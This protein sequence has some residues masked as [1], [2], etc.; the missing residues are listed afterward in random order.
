M[1]PKTNS[2]KVL[3][4]G[5]AI[6]MA[7]LIVFSAQAQASAIQLNEWKRI[8]NLSTQGMC[9]DGN[10]NV[11]VAQLSGLQVEISKITSGGKKSAVINKTGILGHAND[12]T[13]CS[14]DGYIYVATG[15]GDT[16]QTYGIVALDPSRNYKVVGKYKTPQFKKTP[17]GIAYDSENNVFYVKSGETVRVGNFEKGEF[18]S[19]CKC[20]LDYGSN[21]GYT[22][23]GITA[24][25][26]KIYIPLWDKY[27]QKNSVIRVYNIKKKSK[28]EYS[29]KFDSV[30][31]YDDNN[32]KKDKFEIEGLDFSTSDQMFFA[33]NGEK[34]DAVFKVN[35]VDHTVTLIDIESLCFDY[36]YYADTYPDLKAAYGY[37]KT[38][39]QNHWT[40]YGMKE[41]RSASPILDL[42]FYVE[43]NPD[44]KAVYGNNYKAAYDHFIKW[45]YKEYRNSSKY[46]NGA[47]YRSAHSDLQNY[48]SAF[49]INH[50]VKYG[51]KEGRLAG[52]EK[53]V[54]N[55]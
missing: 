31:R 37:N 50:Y 35:Y 41:G 45:G 6:G 21:E 8:D 51:I 24:H 17:A 3:K 39:L 27:G 14:A 5:L 49:L 18:K 42:K 7:S 52:M 55:K 47:Y 36:Q 53:Y 9:M 20:T 33:T 54:M 26:G 10:N 22:N 12:M 28:D 4:R 11:Y 34:G 48:D 15:G 16:A 38:K 1:N 44:L 46:Y 23:Q 43:Q 29:F 32:S 2:K 19:I 25:K 13:Y 40:K 30:E